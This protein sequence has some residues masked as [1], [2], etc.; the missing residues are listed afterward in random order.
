MFYGLSQ[1]SLEDINNNFKKEKIFKLKK[2]IDLQ[3][4]NCFDLIRFI[5]DGSIDLILTD[6][7]YGITQND[8]DSVPDLDRMWSEFNRVIK[9]NGAIVLTAS[10]PFTSKLVVSNL[11]N[12]KYEVIWEKTVSSGQLNVKKQPLRSHESVLI[13]YKKQPIYNEQKTNGLPYN[14]KRKI[15]TKEQNYGKQT[16]SEKN[17]NGYRHAKSII[18]ISNPRIKGGHPTQKPLELMEYFIKTF[19]NEDCTVLDPFMGS[20][21][22]GAACLK[23]NRNFTGFEI[24]EEYF[25]TAS[26]RLYSGK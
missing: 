4:G 7:P 23:L 8:W 5:K 2:M 19:T 11:K 20:G 9:D 18:K 12:F 16:D 13:F 1:I 14:I 3:K 17:N 24:N 22:T 25:N 15:K 21:T 10:Q 6:P 26:T